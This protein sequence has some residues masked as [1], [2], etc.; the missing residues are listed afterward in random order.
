[1]RRVMADDSTSRRSR[2]NR[3]MDATST[4][5]EIAAA[6][7]VEAEVAMAGA[8]AASAGGR[9]SGLGTPTNGSTTPPVTAEARRPGTPGTEAK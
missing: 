9:V 2:R 8:V 6:E 7:F 4:T 3:L 5:A 1:M